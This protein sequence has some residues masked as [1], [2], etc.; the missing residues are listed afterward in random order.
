[1]TEAQF[2]YD[3]TSWPMESLLD[4]QMG[5]DELGADPFI[6]SDFSLTMQEGLNPFWGTEEFS[7]ANEHPVKSSISR[8]YPQMWYDAGLVRQDRAEMKTDT[9]FSHQSTSFQPTD[10]PPTQPHPDLEAT[11]RALFMTPSPNP[12]FPFPGSPTSDPHGSPD[13]SHASSRGWD[14]EADEESQYTFDF[15]LSPLDTQYQAPV[16]THT[17]SSPHQYSDEECLTPLE[18]PDGTTRMTS[19]WLPVDPD[20][21][22]A[23]GS[24]S[25][26]E[27][28]APFQNV[29]HAFF[30]TP[31]AWSYD[32]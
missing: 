31:A 17:L 2:P 9:S 13:P 32:P 7:W 12:L 25:M 23:I 20:A 14:G 1:M 16:Q 29:K 22:F 4:S 27:D 3:I 8:P 6:A 24:M 26:N 10:N 21:G 11:Q 18:M 28:V 30:S 15:G 19:N 5:H